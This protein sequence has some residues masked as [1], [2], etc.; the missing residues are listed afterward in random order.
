MRN[1]TT[2]VFLFFSVIALAQTEFFKTQLL[3][4]KDKLS[5][6]YSSI[7]VD[8]NQVYFNANDYNVYAHDKKNGNLNWSHYT[9]SKSNNAPK[10][11]RNNVFVGGEDRFTQ[12]NSKTGELVRDILLAGLSTQ[13]IIKD[14]IMYCAAISPQIGGAIIAYD[15]KN[16]RTVWQ[17][18]IGHGITH[19]PYFFKNKIVA[20]FEENHW[21][22]LDYHG[23]A[24]DKDTLC[25]YKNKMPPFEESFCN[26]RYD[27]LNQCNKDLMLKKVSIQNA[28]YFYTNEMTAVLKDDKIKIINNKNV[29]SNT[30]D[31]RKILKL[32]K[33]TIN[34]YSEI[35]KVEEST[36][37]VF[38]DNALVVYDFK[39]N[40]TIKSYD[41][42]FWNAHQVVLDGNNL[43]LISKTSGELI[44]LKLNK[45]I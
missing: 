29:V 45:D 41:L 4:P 37:W 13:S 44:G 39:L 33:P 1:K 17:K 9:G 36:I 11:Y 35:L 25:Y 27:L 43:W 7:S 26:I 38:Y 12:L 22:E 5:N 2:L 8:S 21:F 30:I 15:L 20:H 31:I 6:F 32:C 24:L 18:Y 42:S 28:K 34:D 40:K 14:T 16:N 3:F 10:I 19:Q 23:N